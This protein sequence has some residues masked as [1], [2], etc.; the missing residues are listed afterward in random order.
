MGQSFL[1]T[2][3]QWAIDVSASIAQVSR[4]GVII[5]SWA[6]GA[7]IKFEFVRQDYNLKRAALRTDILEGTAV[8]V[9]LSTE[10][11]RDV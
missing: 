2:A 3:Y 8:M 7:Q 11:A 4:K 1:C 10:E 5:V 9:E 6:I